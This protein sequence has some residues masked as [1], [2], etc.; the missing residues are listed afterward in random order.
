MTFNTCS[1]H[2]PVNPLPLCSHHGLQLFLDPDNGQ[3]G[4]M[5]CVQDEMEFYLRPAEELDEDDVCWHP[6]RLAGPDY[7]S[8]WEEGAAYAEEQACAAAEHLSRFLCDD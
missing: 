7:D 4:C 8:R 5:Q 6:A 1:D 2:R 3:P